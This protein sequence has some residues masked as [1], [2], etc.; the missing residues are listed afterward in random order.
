MARAYG[1]AKLVENYAYIIRVYIFY[2]KTYY[3]CLVF[4]CADKSYPLNIL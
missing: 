3:A 1:Y 4:G 2:Y